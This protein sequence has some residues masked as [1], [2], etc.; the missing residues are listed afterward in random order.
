M[1]L[2]KTKETKKHIVIAS[3]FFL[4]AWL[5]FAHPDILETANHSYLLLENLCSGQFFNFYENVMLHENTLYYINNAHYNIFVYVIFA[6]FEL[7]VFI[8]NKLFGF[9][10][11]EVLLYFIAKLV[12]IGFYFGCTYLV[13][14]IAKELS[15]TNEKSAWTSLHTALWAPAFFAVAIMGQ[16]DSICLFFMLLGILFWMRGKLTISALWFGVGAAC[17]F[18]PLLLFAPLVLLKEKRPLYILKYGALSLWLVVPTALLF[19]GRTGDMQ[20][21]NDLMMDRVFAAKFLG[22]V[23]VAILPTLILLICVV[24]YF[25][26]PKEAQLNKI[27]IWLGLCVFTLI[28]LLVDWHPQWIALIAP[29]VVLTTFGEDKKFVWYVLDIV[30]A[31]GFFLLCAIYYPGMLEANLLDFGLVGIFTTFNSFTAGTYN[32]ISFYYTQLAPVFIEI[33][34]ILFAVPLLANVLLKMP[35]QESTLAAKLSAKSAPIKEETWKQPVYLWGIFF[36]SVAFW[37]LP[38]VFTWLKRFGIL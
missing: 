21:F 14:L 15:F 33:A 12:A 34:P 24:M 27:A 25:Y 26:Q 19:H 17:K 13:Y 30:L 31:A 3:L 7:P 1:Q 10:V 36:I 28:F 38:V 6:L 5:L 9:A 22:G 18:F 29:F 11:Q 8:I 20:V 35:Y 37:A 2:L 4:L 23:E 16:Y 32:T